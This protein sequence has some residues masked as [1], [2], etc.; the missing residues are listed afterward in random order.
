MPR[1]D[2]RG[3]ATPD[4]PPGD[5]S[6]P[7]DRTRWR[8]W[9]TPFGRRWFFG[10]MTLAAF[11]GSYTLGLRFRRTE[12]APAPSA[13]PPEPLYRPPPLGLPGVSPQLT[14]HRDPL[15]VP[16]VLRPDAAGRVTV[17]LVV[18][19]FRLHADLPPS[20]LWTYGGTPV[21]PTIEV[22]RG[23]DV[24]IA[25]RNELD[26][27]LPVAVA[28]VADTSGPD[29]EWELPGLRGAPVVPGSAELAPFTAPELV[30]TLDGAGSTTWSENPVGPGEVR[31]TVH[32][33]DRPAAA[34]WYRDATAGVSRLTAA[35]GLT[36]GL[37]VI[38][39]DAEDALGLPS[40]DREIPLVLA[41]R[42][43]DTDGAGRLTGRVVYKTTADDGGPRG[44]VRRPFTGPFTLVNGVVRPYVELAADRYRFR[45]LNAAASRTYRLRLAG[46]AG[47]LTLVGTDGGLLPE[48]VPVDGPL[49]LAPGERADVVADL[50]DLADRTVRLVDEDAGGAGVLELRIG[51]PAGGPAVP[52]TAGVPAEATAAPVAERFVALTPNG[53]APARL[54][55][56]VEVDDGGA[57]GP[58]DGIVRL[59]DGR[60][61]TRTLRRVAGYGDD[62]ATVHAVEGTWERWTVLD[63]G[64]AGPERTLRIGGFTF[65]VERRD[66]Y[67]MRGFTPLP[68]GGGG[69]GSPLRW[70]GRDPVDARDAGP[71]DVVAVVPGSVVTVL[72]R[73]GAAGRFTLGSAG[74]DLADAGLVRPLTI[75]PA[76]IAALDPHA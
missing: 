14:A 31:W 75:L 3:V 15:P 67:D 37:Y 7:D 26:G 32:A 13:P 64:T 48:A 65:R 61:R 29:R 9:S 53:P 49:V 23:A 4:E 60:G 34:L 74:A 10:N 76:G 51:R 62:P 45:L 36:G 73:Y 42:N 66:T 1:A 50:G 11:F 12:P 44:R 69:T 58:V 8:P 22:R 47:T 6:R 55:E 35:A 2:G 30:G 19:R 24:R 25:W 33:N 5:G 28:E 20:T 41:D 17:R 54:W 38:R 46:G 52:V 43:L 21:A 57:D 63:L 59:V 70:A 39:D 71:R 40:G 68:G 72:G 56:L 16:A 18:A 27:P